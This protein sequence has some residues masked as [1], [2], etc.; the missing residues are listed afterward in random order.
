[1]KKHGYM[2]KFIFMLLAFTTLIATAQSNTTSSATQPEGTVIYE[3]VV[4]L[5]GPFTGPN[6]EPLT[7]MPKQLTERYELLFSGHKSL[8]Q[9][10]PDAAA[11]AA[12]ASG[13][14]MDMM[15]PTRL[16]GGDADVVYQDFTQ[17]TRLTQNE[18]RAKTYLVTDSIAAFDWKLSEETKEILGHNARKATA[19]R[20]S[21]RTIMGMENGILKSQELPDTSVIVVWFAPGIPV[22]AGPAYS[23]GLPGLILELDENGGRSV[24]RAVSVS[25]KVA[26]GRLKVPKNGRYISAIAFRAEQQ[27]WR[28]GMQQRMQRGGR[29]AMPYRN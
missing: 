14:T 8:W 23:G 7:N 9:A 11:E 27:K 6:G 24:F 15:R 20:Y 10:L 5:D 26:A 25:Q 4:K 17:G 12:A 22:P 19:Y 16:D 1:L 28:T 13:N 2:K 3:C 21:T 29:V 18:L